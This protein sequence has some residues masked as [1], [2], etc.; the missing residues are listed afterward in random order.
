MLKKYLN[1]SNSLKVFLNFSFICI[2]TYLIALTLFLSM[3]SKELHCFEVFI[4]AKIMLESVICSLT[5]TIIFSLIIKY[6]IYIKTQ[7]K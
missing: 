6:E 1:Y 7:K 2:L 3:P 4:R 5:F